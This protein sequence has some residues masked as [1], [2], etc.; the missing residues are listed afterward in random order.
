MTR[1]I[2]FSDLH[3]QLE[4][5]AQIKARAAEIRTELC[6][7]AGDLTQFGNFDVA[8]GIAAR[9]KN[10]PCPVYFIH[11]NCDP[12]DALRAFMNAPGYIHSKTIELDRY[13]LYGY[14]NVPPTPFGTYNEVPDEVIRSELVPKAS[15]P[16]IL[17][18][19][20]PPLDIND[21]TRGGPHGGSLILRQVLEEY[22]PFLMIHGH[23]HEAP[24]YSVLNYVTNEIEQMVWFSSETSSIY[25]IENKIGRGT[26]INVAAAKLGRWVEIEVQKDQISITPKQLSLV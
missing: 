23:I 21:L 1:I 24:G 12:P 9:L 22:Q 8:R 16:L 2:A 13:S 6:L 26:I 15:K 7:I 19:H 25:T 5:L 14:G 17:V 20:A 11:G 18:T 10:F 3:G 4:I